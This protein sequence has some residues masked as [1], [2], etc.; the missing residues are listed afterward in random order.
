M[1]GIIDY[2]LGNVKA[3]ANIYKEL[4][5]RHVVASHPKEL[6][7]VTRLIVPGVGAFDQAMAR[8]ERSGMRERLE[9]L[10]LGDGLPGLGWVAGDVIRFR[11]PN[12]QLGLQIPHMGWNDASPRGSGGLFA[13]LEEGARFYFLHSFHVRV[14]DDREILAETNYGGKFPCAVARDNIYGVQ[15]HP[16]KSHRSGV[17]LLKNFAEL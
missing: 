11:S 14:S 8:L 2:Q 13:S 1:I 4:G 15:F 12:G 5:I 9:E 10:V 3:F 17:Q 6:A 7:G 16:E